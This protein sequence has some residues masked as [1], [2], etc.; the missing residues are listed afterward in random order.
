M[1]VGK[2]RLEFIGQCMVTRTWD[3]P[4]YQRALYQNALEI[5]QDRAEMV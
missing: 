3:F 1:L 2:I 4:L 5:F